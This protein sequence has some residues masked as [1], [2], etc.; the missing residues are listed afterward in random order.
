LGLT[1]E[2]E[3]RRNK[4]HVRDPCWSQPDQGELRIGEKIFAFVGWE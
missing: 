3:G 1:C 2:G 4:A